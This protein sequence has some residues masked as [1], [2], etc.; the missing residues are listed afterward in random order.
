MNF[1]DP[2]LSSLSGRLVAAFLS[3][4]IIPGILLAAGILSGRQTASP[5]PLTIEKVR[6]NVYM[7]KGGSGANCFLIAG[8]K[9][10]L[11]VDAKM[12]AESF[13]EMLSEIQKTSPLPLGLIILTHSD[14]DHINGLRG[15]DEK[16]R[17][18][19]HH[20]TYEEMLPL[21]EQTPELKDIL[22]TE[23]YEGNKT[24][25][26]EGTRLEL[27][28]FGPAHTSGDTIIF[29]PEAKIAIV[30]D[31]IFLGRDP[32]IHR[33]KNGTFF[34][35][36]RTLEAMLDF[37]PPIELFLS[38]HADPAG[39]QEVARLI[40]SLKEKEAR[41]REM[42]DQGKNLDEI[43][44]AFG[45]QPTP[46]GLPVRRPPLVEIIYQEITEQKR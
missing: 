35:Y 45:V 24:I 15:L 10:N 42:V 32:L 30:G 16:V 19:S 12:T 1:S 46:A 20:R 17:I 28:N 11:L 38:G 5:P 14:R 44:A 31:L 36:L 40:A 6:A 23:T 27:M 37:K 22:P 41:V 34:G 9:S 43:K 18:I 21:V 3:I 25:D 13:K 8:K 2:R 29:V 39:R 33:H 26:F 4:L 7:I